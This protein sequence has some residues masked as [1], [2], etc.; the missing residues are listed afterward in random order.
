[1]DGTTK[2]D[3][4]MEMNVSGVKIVGR[5]LEGIDDVEWL[6]RAV[7]KLWKIIDDID[8]AD[9]ICKER[10]VCFRQLVM[11]KQKQKQRH[12]VLVSDGYNLFMPV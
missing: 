7:K 4:L 1:M 5:S 2:T 6:Q 8:T 12:N 3:V 9:D 11:E 10:E